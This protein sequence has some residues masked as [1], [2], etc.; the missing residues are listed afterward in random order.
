MTV[1]ISQQAKP[2]GAPIGMAVMPENTHDGKHMKAAYG[3]VKDDL[4]YGSTMIFDA[5]ANHKDI[6][7]SIIDNGKHFLTRK[8]LNKSDDGLFARFSEDS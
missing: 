5:G 8:R 4:S 3:Q 2:L 7:D 6:L 1:G